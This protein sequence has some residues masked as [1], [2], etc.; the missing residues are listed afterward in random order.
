MSAIIE[1]A[2]IF[3][4]WEL[5]KYNKYYF[6]NFFVYKIMSDLVFTVHILIVN[7]CRT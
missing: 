6:N 2:K 7:Y 1:L 5:C 4:Q 3:T